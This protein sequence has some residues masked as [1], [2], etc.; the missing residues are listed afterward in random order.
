M[1]NNNKNSFISFVIFFMCL[2]LFIVYGASSGESDTTAKAD[3]FRI[4]AYDVKLNV[5]EDLKVYVTESITVDWY[6]SNHHGIYK[7][8]P[9]WYEYTGSDNKTVKRKSIISDYRALY[10][11]FT[12]DMVKKKARIKIGS[13]N[14]F[15]GYGEK[16]YLIEYTYDMGKDPFKGF[17]EFIFHA[18]GDYWGTSI[19]NASVEITLPKQVTA[20]DIKFF[21]DKYRKNDITESM[22]VKVDGNT[23]YAKTDQALDSALTVDVLLP[24]GYFVGGSNNYGIMSL[25]CIIGGI[26]LTVI[27]FMTWYKYGKN[28]PKKAETVEFYPPDG[29]SS[30]EIGYIY[31]NKNIKKL[32]ISLVVSLASKGY[33]KIDTDDKKKVKITNLLNEPKKPAGL[34][35]VPKR[36]A[37]IRQ[38]KDIDGSLTSAETLMMKLLFKK[39]SY[40]ELHSNFDKFDAVKDSLTQKGYIKV[41]YDNVNEVNE[42]YNKAVNSANYQDYL[43]KLDEYNESIK[44]YPKLN[45]YEKIVYDNLSTCGTSFYLSDDTNFYKVFE[46]V[47]DELEIGIYEKLNDM[48][49]SSKK[50]GA[51]IRTILTAVCYFLA[52]SYFE[53]L[54]PQLYILYKI[55]LICVPIGI[56]CRIVMGRKTTYGEEISAKVL[57]FRN[58][59]IKVEKD[60]LERL[61]SQNPSYFYNI[62]PYTYVLEISRKW[63]D[64][65]E[66]IYYPQMDMGSFDY[67]DDSAYNHF[68][69]DVYFPSSSSHSSGCSSCGGGCSSCGGGCSS[70]GGGGSW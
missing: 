9:Q 22:N 61:V 29:L 38:E 52:Y 48:E 18:Y 27:T 43:K 23:I 47:E 66:N 57:G 69:D 50:S 53:D 59:L 17:D 36:K 24:E 26:A 20:K 42:E 37:E 67:S 10:D 25:I 35:S 19:N 12:V 44:D 49:A 21:T 7:F 8:T 41:I 63:I 64:K 54:N 28:H 39:S 32:T 33:I 6:E 5:Q 45:K 31:G 65:F 60:Q 34:S 13:A 4:S 55:C 46:D 58:F 40:K 2:N 3:G 70:C 68:I 14:S 30:A 11:P 62:L 51:T 1:K 56:L 15:V 16:T